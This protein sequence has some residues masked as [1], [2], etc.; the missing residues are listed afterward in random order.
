MRA[1]R[2]I[3]AAVAILAGCDGARPPASTYYERNIAPILRGRC[4]TSGG[5][6]CHTDDGSGRANGNLDL[7]SYATLTRRPDVLR[8]FGS[9]PYPL[10]L[11]KGL[12]PD[13]TG[14]VKMTVG[15][16]TAVPVIIRHAGGSLLQ[17]NSD[18]FFT[19][20]RW[21]E[22]GATENGLPPPALIKEHGEC[23][24]LIRFDLFAQPTLDGVDVD[25]D[26]YRRFQDQV[27][28]WIRG[29]RDARNVD[30]GGGC[31]G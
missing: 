9:Y 27:W 19:L 7:T 24:T 21:L 5:G 8:R 15:D 25:S 16:V 23:S 29:G 13:E 1:T 11:L 30:R 12:A 18:T 28:P 10:L 22:N 20:E 17:M 26:N 14:T 31:L 3:L 2:S 4:T 6:P